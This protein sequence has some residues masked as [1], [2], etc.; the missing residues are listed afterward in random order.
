MLD[1]AGLEFKIKSLCALGSSIKC[2]F[3]WL[4][5]WNGLFVQRRTARARVFWFRTISFLWRYMN[6]LLS[7][8]QSSWNWKSQSWRITNH[9]TNSANSKSIQRCGGDESIEGCSIESRARPQ[10]TGGVIS[11]QHFLSDHRGLVQNDWWVSPSEG[12]ASNSQLAEKLA[13][14]DIFML[15]ITHIH[16][17]FVG[18]ILLSCVFNGREQPKQRPIY[19]NPQ[20]NMNFCG[21]AAQCCEG[22]P[23][24]AELLQYVN[25]EETLAQYCGVSFS[26]MSLW[27]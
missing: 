19:H 8:T 18:S 3:K 6:R 20:F 26:D 7:V 12:T 24:K 17:D 10:W 9:H 25:T 14:E 1:T 23:C 15:R 27:N 22:L 2:D 5:C 11:L 16:N 21:T 13:I 4:C